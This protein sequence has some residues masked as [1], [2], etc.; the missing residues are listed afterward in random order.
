MHPPEQL[1]RTS[2]FPEQEA[3]SDLSLLWLVLSPGMPF[4]FDKAISAAQS[5]SV[6][7]ETH[8]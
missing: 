7:L 2:D 8:V 4:C 3:S 1:L 5:H 6:S